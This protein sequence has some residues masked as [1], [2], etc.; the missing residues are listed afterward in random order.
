MSNF[1]HLHNH[2]HYSILDA[3]TTPK[4]LVAAAVEDGQK[5][6]AI[7]DHGVMY[8]V[9][10][11][12]KEAKEKGIK[13]LIGMEAYLANGSRLDKTALTRA[14][15]KKN[16][17]HILLIAKD[18]IGYKNLVKLSSIGYTEGF[19]Y[20][21]RID[22]EVLE[23]YKNGLICTSACM[24]GII[25][26]HIIDNQYEKALAESQYYKD[27]FGDDFY[28]EIQNHFL[29]NDPLIIQKVPEIARELNIKLIATND[30]HYISKDNAIPH[31][32]LLHI[33]DNSK[34]EDS[35]ANDILKYGTAE[36]YFKTTKQMKELFSDF[37][38]ALSNT[39]EIAEK[40]NFNFEKKTVFPEFP[41]P[42]ESSAQDLNEYLKELVYKGLKDRFDIQ[43]D[44]LKE[45]IEYELNVIIKMGFSGY[46]LIVANFIEAAHKLNVSVGPGRGSAVGSLVAYCLKITNVNPLPY[47]LLFERFLNPERFSMP[48]ID[49]DFSDETRDL[50]INFVKEKYGADAVAQICTFGKLSA[51]AVL[52]DVGRV[53]NISLQQV[54]D[55]TRQIQISQGRVPK[56]SEILDL[57][58][59]KWLKDTEDQK[60][61]QLIEYSQK[62]ENRNRSVGTHAA[63]IVITPGDVSDY[64][65]L[66]KGTENK[67]S[68]EVATQFSMLNLEEIGLL[69]MDFL[70][71]KT[72]SIIDR[73]LEMI[74]ENFKIKINIDQIDFED[75]KTYDMISNG[76]TLAVFQF[77]SN[78]MQEYLKK[79][80]PHNLEELTAMNALYRPGP[81]DN[82]PE[83]I[84]RKYGRKTI[85]YL[86]PLME[87]ALK[88]TYGIIVYQEQVMQLVQ[89][90]A[91][92]TLGQA[93]ILRRAMGKKDQRYM[94]K[95]KPLFINGAAKHGINDKLAEEIF[96]LIYKFANYG[97][98]KSHSLAYSYLAFQTA[99]LKT[100]YTT[101]FLA[102]VMTSEITTLPKIVQLIEEAKKFNIKVV[103]PDINRSVANFY[104]LSKTIF[105][106]MAAIKNV[107]VAV[108]NQI[109][110]A[111]DTKPFKSFFDFIERV[112]SKVINRRTLEA[113]ICAGAFDSIHPNQRASLFE[114]IDIAIEYAK[115][116]QDTS[117]E[118]ESLFGGEV[119]EQIKVEP[120][121][122]NVPEWDFL[123]LL[124]KEKEFLNFYISG[125]PMQNY[126]HI[127]RSINSANITN[128]INRKIHKLYCGVVA[129]INTKFDKKKNQICFVNVE[130]F[131]SRAECIFWSDAYEKYADKIKAGEILIVS[132]SFNENEDDISIVVN[133]VLDISNVIDNYFAGYKIWI[134]IDEIDM[135]QKIK[136][137]YD[138]YYNEKYPH[139]IIKF[140]VH[141]NE[142]TIKDTYINL[143]CPIR[144]DL[145]TFNQISEI[146]GVSNVKLEI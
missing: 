89:I 108:V 104:G 107:G 141:N 23:K 55:I 47:N 90:I 7:T 111:R 22:K 34:I 24:G 52:T 49:I 120:D 144:Y 12:Y 137:F 40:C 33:R 127:I 116:S 118:M 50:V 63:G 35:I 96:G 46:F 80:K 48:D 119:N 32:I 3:L 129:D 26:S 38:E 13:P 1:V 29:P 66:Y 25:G 17:F 86:H 81:M 102:S 15:K 76:D 36:Y 128:S 4:E 74:E 100:H 98:N 126:E 41:I 142:N 94:D 140:F 9:Y 78:G 134:N 72:L 16:Y 136:L 62:L 27:L 113:L 20:R 124:R 43:T 114:S 143:K 101:E 146:F 19:Y 71:L 115:S 133:E 54:K 130:E 8:G 91:D 145:E 139:R 51:R 21:P 83:F 58:N 57:P 110:Q 87:R 44:E 28:L 30:I 123:E 77:E 59:L 95:M 99:W 75:K 122:I 65:P 93:D 37:P 61:K 69:K 67:S 2:T 11:F 5:A 88:T 18:E 82:I 109:V 6:I 31:N 85:E 97:F 112:D 70:G 131:N 125:N 42:K 103:P 10:E 106:G 121:L 132:G 84:D 64:V 138:K 117:T 79:L 105:F 45:R 135:T 68:V 73:T 39:S 92:F 60:L 53:L 56:I 14:N